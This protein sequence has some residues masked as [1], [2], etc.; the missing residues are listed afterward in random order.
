MYMSGLENPFK[1]TPA[2]P[3]EFIGR[4]EILLRWEERLTPNSETWNNAVG[5]LVVGSGGVGKTS[6]LNKMARVAQVYDAHVIQLDLGHYRQLDREE[7][8]FSFLNTHLPPAQKMSSRMRHLLDLPAD[9]TT[10]Q[11]NLKFLSLLSHFAPIL[12]GGGWALNLVL[13]ALILVKHQVSD[14]SYFKRSI[15]WQY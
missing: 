13:Q 15:V 7:D 5:W 8:F 12:I 11:V 10:A 9:A 1:L 2:S 14:R 4:D 6:L 3:T